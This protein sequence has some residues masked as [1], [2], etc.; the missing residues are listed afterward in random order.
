MRRLRIAHGFSSMLRIRAKGDHAVGKV[1]DSPKLVLNVADFDDAKSLAMDEVHR[2]PNISIY[3]SD[4][5]SLACISGGIEY[6]GETIASFKPSYNHM[7][8]EWFRGIHHY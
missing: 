5:K 1:V 3:L 8:N 2:W 6:V 4:D 7:V